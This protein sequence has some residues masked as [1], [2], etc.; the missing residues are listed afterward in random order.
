MRTR[1]IFA[2]IAAIALAGCAGGGAG[3]PFPNPSSGGSSPMTQQEAAQSGADSAMSEIG[4]A[5]LDSSLFSGSIGVVLS[6]AQAPIQPATSGTCKNGVI[7]TITVVSPTETQYDVQLFYDAA[8]TQLRRD[9]F[10]DVQ[11]PSPST[12]NITRTIKNYNNSGLLLSTRQASYSV[13][14]SPGNF[15]AV[16]TSALTV[17]TSSSPQE[18][19]GH[20]VTV[21]P[22]NANTWTIAGNSARVENVAVPSIN[23]SF[24]V[25]AQ[26]VNVTATTDVSGDVTFAGTRNKTFYKG[27]LGSLSIPATPPFSISGGTQL[28]TGTINGS[29][30][31]D[32]ND[33]LVNVAL[34]GTLANGDTIVV[35]SS[36]SGASISINGTISSPGGTPL[37]TFS[38]DRFGDGIITYANGSQALIIDW[39][40]VP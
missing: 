39:H 3:S 24:G 32:S 11:M 23:E 20:Q 10:S 6:S 25:A 5:S 9:T 1:I 40:V 33:E 19:D 13:T 29:I 15:S 7:K 26:L 34:N 14:G 17:G 4:A 36:G 8:C 16:V 37:A 22:Q 28:G 30:E 21:A 27:A 18:Q 31:F 35:T 2:L 38:V 12:E